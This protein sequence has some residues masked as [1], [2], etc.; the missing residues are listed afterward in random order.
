MKTSIYCESFR[1]I[2][3]SEKIKVTQSLITKYSK[4]ERGKVLKA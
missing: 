3:N 1:G 4:Y 2:K